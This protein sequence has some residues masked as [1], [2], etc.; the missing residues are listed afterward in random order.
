MSTAERRANGP[1]AVVLVSGGLD[2]TTALAITLAQE[3]APIVALSFEYGQRHVV[4]IAAAKRVCR[5]YG[6]RDHVVIPLGLG[7]IGASSLT[8]M[9]IEVPKDRLAIQRASGEGAPLTTIPTTYVPARNTIFLAIALALAE[10]R[11]ID[12]LVIGANA[13]DYSGY[14]DCRPEYFRAFESLAALATREGVEGRA[15]YRIDAPLLHLTKADIVREGMRLG[16]PYALTHS[17]Y[18][19]VMA[20]SSAGAIDSQ[21]GSR[22]YPSDLVACGRCDSCVLRLR[23]FAQAGCIDPITYATRVL[24]FSQS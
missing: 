16:A 22:D 24:D 23:G 9:A 11:G 2:S 5:Y 21:T 13:L 1:G 19:P 18:D 10:A 17:C 20:S 8:D 14:P 6:V 3:C 15:T 7:T 12:R 4:E